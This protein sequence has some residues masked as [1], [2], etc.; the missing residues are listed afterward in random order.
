MIVK[1]SVYA[2]MMVKT[3]NVFVGQFDVEYTV[4]EHTGIPVQA[5][6]LFKMSFMDGS[7]SIFLSPVG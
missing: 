5:L 2:I 6:H 1:I 3:L 7:Q 4:L